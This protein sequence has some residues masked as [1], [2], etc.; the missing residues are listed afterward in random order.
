MSILEEFYYGNI[1]P[2][3]KFVKNGSEYQKLNKELIDI[4]DKLTA[5]LN[6]EEK[7]FYE[8]IEEIMY[9]LGHISEKEYYMDGFCT[10]VQLII[11]IMNFKSANFY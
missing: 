7:Q 3:S 6:N 2:S 5:T 11:D 1:S 9:E 4:S 10:G 8:R